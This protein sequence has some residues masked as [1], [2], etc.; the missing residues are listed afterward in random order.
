MDTTPY[1]ALKQVYNRKTR[2]YELVVV[3]NANLVLIHDGFFV[4]ETDKPGEALEMI[5]AGRYLSGKNWDNS[6]MTI[7]GFLGLEPEKT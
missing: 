6:R 3:R 4:Y 7:M 5:R 2:I 1:T